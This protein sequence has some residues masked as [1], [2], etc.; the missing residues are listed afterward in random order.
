MTQGQDCEDCVEPA[1][2][3]PLS[4]LATWR[5]R[6]V[7]YYLEKTDEGIASFDHLAGVVLDHEEEATESERVDSILHHRTLPHLQDA[8]IVEYDRRSGA[9]RYRAD[10]IP[11]ALLECIREVEQGDD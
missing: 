3:E 10:A 1:L 6:C 5:G 2:D 9:V 8:G 7:V 4:A 11:D